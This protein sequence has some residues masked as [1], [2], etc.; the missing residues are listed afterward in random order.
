MGTQVHYA[1]QRVLDGHT[2]FHNG[3]EAD[4]RGKDIGLAA[5]GI[6]EPTRFFIEATLDK[7]ELAKPKAEGVI[8]LL[9]SWLEDDSGYDEETW[10]QL[11]KT[12]NLERHIQGARGLFN[13]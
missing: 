5:G 13:G 12:L 9:R 2:K 1:W 11:K 4:R 8:S 3:H 6:G 7:L 10:A